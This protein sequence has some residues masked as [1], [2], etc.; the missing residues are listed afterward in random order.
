[1]QAH[2]TPIEAAG[3]ASRF[4]A[5][6]SALLTRIEE[7]QADSLTEAS[8]GLSQ[9]ARLLLLADSAGE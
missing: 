4:L 8:R 9:H 1:M 6:A 3:Q 7:T 5:A 2:S